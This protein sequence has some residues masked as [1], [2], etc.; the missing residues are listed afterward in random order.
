M[1]LHYLASGS[2]AVSSW[3]HHYRDITAACVLCPVN[4]F[5][6]DQRLGTIT[7]VGSISAAELSVLL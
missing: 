6:G 7:S 2:K 5:P 4:C 1:E 3:Q